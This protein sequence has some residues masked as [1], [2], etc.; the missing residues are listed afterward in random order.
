M[1]EIVNEN[2]FVCN[3]LTGN[4]NTII[5][6]VLIGADGYCNNPLFDVNHVKFNASVVPDKVYITKNIHEILQN[7]LIPEICDIIVEYLQPTC[8]ILA[9]NYSKSSGIMEQSLT[10]ELYNSHNYIVMDGA[11][12]LCH[13]ITFDVV[14]RL[15]DCYKKKI[16]IDYS[17]EKHDLSPQGMLRRTTLGYFDHGDYRVGNQFIGKF[18]NNQKDIIEHKADQIIQARWRRTPGDVMRNMPK[19]MGVYEDTNIVTAKRNSCVIC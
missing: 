18:R 6:Q 2:L 4:E 19:W 15:Y 11:Y 1:T 7:D 16:L 9:V 8:E 17:Y 5:V 13:Y 3:E 10:N 14:L 12:K